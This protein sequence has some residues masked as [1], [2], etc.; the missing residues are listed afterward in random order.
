MTTVGASRLLPWISLWLAVAACTSPPRSPPR[1]D[2]PRGAASSPPS[3]SLPALDF[4]RLADVALY[5]FRLRGAGYGAALST[6]DV[7][8]RPL[9]SVSVTPHAGGGSSTRALEVETAEVRRGSRSVA[10][11][12]SVATTPDGALQ[13]IRGPVVETLRNSAAGLSQTWTFARPPAGSGDLTVRV[14]TRGLALVASR[15]DGLHFADARGGPGLLYGPATFVDARGVRTAAHERFEGDAIV[16]TVPATALDRAAYPAV[17]DPLLSPERTLGE[18]LVIAPPTQEVEPAIAT[19][20]TDYFVVWSDQRTD[21]G[22]FGARVAADGTLRDPV[23]LR[24]G[25]HDP[26]DRDGRYQAHEPAIA[27]T[28]THYLVAFRASFF[29]NDAHLRVLRVGRD[30]VP[31][32]RYPQTLVLTGSAVRAPAVA[33]AADGSALVVWRDEYPLG[34]SS[35]SIYGALVAP[36]GRSA[37]ST[38]RLIATRTEAALETPT[39]ASDGTGFLVGWVDRPTRSPAEARAIRVMPSG[40]RVGVPV[41]LAAPSPIDP[42]ISLAFNGTD[43]VAVWSEWVDAVRNYRIVTARVRTDGTRRDATPTPLTTSGGQQTDPWI[44]RQGA[45][46]LVTWSELTFGPGGSSRTEV[47]S[48]RVRDD[49]TPLDPAGVTVS[50]GDYRGDHP[51]AVA[52]SRGALVVWDGSAVGSSTASVD[53]FARRLSVD[54]AVTGEQLLLSRGPVERASPAVASDGTQFLVVW[55]ERRTP[56]GALYAARVQADGTVIDPVGIVVRDPHRPGSE[57][58]IAFNGTHYLV[59]WRTSGT[60]SGRRL[61]RDGRLVD[62]S[63]LYFGTASTLTNSLGPIASDG[64]GWL[65]VWSDNRRSVANRTDIYAALVR[66]DGTLGVSDIPLAATAEDESA[67]AAGFDGSRYLVA[68]QTFSPSAV[69]SAVRGRHVAPDGTMAPTVEYSGRGASPRVVGNGMGALVAFE[70]SIAGTAQAAASVVGPDG[71]PGRAVTLSPTT[72][73]QFNLAAAFDG[74]HYVVAWVGRGATEQ[75]LFAQALRPDGSLV[76][77]RIAVTAAVER[78]NYPSLASDGRGHTLFAWQRADYPGEVFPP[79]HVRTL[80]L[81]RLRR[82]AACATDSDCG[83][84][85]CVDR[86]CC[87][88]AC[89]RGLLDDCQVCSAA[90]GSPADGTCGPAPATVTCR[91]LGGVC[92]RPALCDGTSTRCPDNFVPAGTACTGGTCNAVGVCAR[93]DAGVD[94]GRT[95][96]GRSDA[97][98]SDAGFDAGRDAR[99]DVAAVIDSSADVEPGVDADEVGPDAPMVSDEDAGPVDTPPAVSGCAC[100]APSTRAAGWWPWAMVLLVL[101][102]TRGK[103]GDQPRASRRDQQSSTTPSQSSSMPFEQISATGVPGATEHTPAS[104]ETCTSENGSW[105]TT[106]PEV[107]SRR[108]WLSPQQSATPEAVVAQT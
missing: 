46:A 10:H 6:Y 76:G 100:R 86:V 67:P 85:F 106:K 94:A 108:S 30:G 107:P 39:V 65:V 41:A 52:G 37:L 84:G 93:L 72:S 95:D 19:D 29:S 56:D 99:V 45:G 101:M 15:T 62:T 1:A 88:S 8:V 43:Y 25:V 103:R 28:G 26:A 71:T 36:D 40:E 57:P 13:I 96:A 68:W 53:I 35:I 22:L 61:A 34:P 89:G 87:E 97:G 102:R 92:M 3:P 81:T 60:P 23:G 20:G 98:R 47:R 33:A 69:A 27:Y 44:T 104:A 82:G 77:E 21:V 64:S 4:A 38:P 74:E 58:R 91:A 83:E 51:A 66:A 12:A 9:G 42:G 78:D 32:D 14:R 49:G 16:L 105:D 75:G 24:L 70:Q 18:P 73:P 11:G 50:A 7:A 31:I 59:A 79:T 55:Y 2:P 5:A 17:L 90:A 63:D 54:G 80:V 48:G